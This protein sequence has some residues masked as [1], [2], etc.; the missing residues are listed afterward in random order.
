V[1]D[2]KA[3]DQDRGLSNCVSLIN[4]LLQQ[5]AT[6]VKQ[7]ITLKHESGEKS[8][9]NFLPVACIYCSVHISCYHCSPAWS[10]GYSNY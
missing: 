3:Q 9:D 10:S 5:K 1:K 8:L 2:S 7:M 4:K 6:K